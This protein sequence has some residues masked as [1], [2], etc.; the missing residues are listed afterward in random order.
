[1][2]NSSSSTTTTFLNA[3]LD[4]A[5]LFNSFFQSVFIK[6]S[7]A[8][9]FQNPSQLTEHVISYLSCSVEEV[10]KLLQSIDI[11]KATGPDNIPPRILKECAMELAL[12]L[13]NFFNFTLSR[14]NIPTDWKV[15]NVVPIFKSG[16]NNLADNYHP[17]SLTSVIVKTGFIQKI[18]TFFQ[19]L[20][21]DQIYF[22]RTLH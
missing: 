11:N 9:D 12:P 17:I 3:Q 7:E 14:G 21:K 1:M 8:S 16:K 10:A 4:K 13:T 2:W 6:D 18:E 5:N 19:G 20:F 22:S 15:A